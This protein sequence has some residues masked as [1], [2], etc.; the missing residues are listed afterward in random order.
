MSPTASILSLSL[1]L[2]GCFPAHYPIDIKGQGQLSCL[3]SNHTHFLLVDDG[4]QGKYGVEIELRTRLE[5][6]ISEKKMGHKGRTTAILILLE[7]ASQ[8]CVI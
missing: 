3:D 8:I 1:S 7:L 4:T 6:C 5:K 2:Q